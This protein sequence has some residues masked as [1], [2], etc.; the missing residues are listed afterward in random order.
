MQ[1]ICMGFQSLKTFLQNGFKWV[2]DLSQFSENFIKKVDVQHLKRLFN[3]HKDLP[4]LPERKKV[5]K[6]EKLICSIEDKEKY[7]IHIRALKQALN[8]GLK[9]KK[10]HRVI[11]F[12]Q[13]DWLKPYI[14]MNTEL[15]KKAQNEFEK[16]CDKNSESSYIGYLD[17]NNLYGWAISQKLSTNG[18][19]W[20]EKVEK[21]IWLV[22]F[23]FGF[24]RLNNS[25]NLFVA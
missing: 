7:V 19:K 8:H 20:V 16:N 17:A 22:L 23:G 14:D 3:L 15:R 2:E 1:I 13:K 24:K 4:F 9:L 21:L 10:V 11:Q 25:K 18:F 6:V 12:I 5:E